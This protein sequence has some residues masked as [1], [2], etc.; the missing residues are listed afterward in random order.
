MAATSNNKDKSRLLGIDIDSLTAGQFLDR[1][2]TFIKSGKPHQISYL[3]ADCLNKCWSD[4]LY[5]EVISE[6][7]LVYA[8]G[9][10][11]VWASRLFGNPL[12]ERLNANDLLPQFC[13]RSEEKNYRIFLLGG[14]KGIAEKTAEDL[15]TKYPNLQIVGCHHGYFSGKKEEEDVI[16]LIHESKVDILIVG[17]GAPKQELWIKNNIDRLGA[18]VA[19]GV[20]GLLDYSA[21]GLQRAPVWMRKAGMEWFWRLCLEPR[22]LWRRY[23][24]GNLLFTFRVGFLIFA[25]AL[26]ATLAWFAAYALRAFLIPH[27][28]F[29]P[30]YLL[31]PLNPFNNYIIALPMIIITWIIIC[32]SMD[33]Y[34]RQTFRT[35]FE[36]LSAIVKMSFLFL[37]TSMAVAF[38]LKDL[39]LGRSVLILSSTM[40]FMMMVVTRLIWSSVEKSLFEEGIGRVRTLIVGSDQYVQKAIDRLQTD[41]NKKYMI[42]GILDDDYAPGDSIY[43]QP[44][45]GK[46]HTLPEWAKTLA[47]DEIFFADP[48]LEKRNLLNLVASCGENTSVRQYNILTDLFGVITDHAFFDADDEIP[49]KV[50]KRGGITP[51]EQILK[52]F[53]D[54]SMAGFMLLCALSFFPIICILIRLSS[55]GA[56][57]FRH[58]RIGLNGQPFI[59]Y[60][61]RTMY[62]EVNEYEEA[63]IKVDDSRILPIGRFLRRTSLDELPQLWNV[64][65]GEMSMVGPRPEM[66]F[67]VED[68][69]PWQRRRLTVVPGITGLWQISGRKDRPLHSNLEYDFYYIQNQSLLF[70]IIIL[71]KTFPVVLFGKG[72]Y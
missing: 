36:E 45:L 5:R 21:K 43:G 2:D 53:L 51:F 4:R 65:K 32:A 35:S 64:I 39:S 29:L 58:K 22:R 38:L 30:G 6:S 71:L 3:N 9:M 12:P 42:L 70:D 59:M 18:P 13:Q 34:R 28:A 10:G 1:I 56:A 8:D 54:I 49:F 69:E 52:R 63:P 44:I 57:I 61:F 40:S 17:M 15:K 31:K 37:I 50:L 14:E 41:R 20:G 60:K 72:A 68:Y 47:A 66:S 24:L 25:D 7:D 67:I 26:S 48:K 11:V 62:Q 27:I 46:V 23:L 33:L 55:T 16:T 19:W